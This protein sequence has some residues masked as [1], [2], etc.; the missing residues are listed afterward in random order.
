MTQ[1]RTVEDIKKLGTILGV[2]A[3]PDDE[4]Y[5]MG[6]IMAAAVQ[7][8]QTVACITATR[9]EAGIQD[10]SRW[11]AHKLA[12]I[13]EQELTLCLEIIGDVRHHWLTYKDGHL[14]NVEEQE[15]V[16]AVAELMGQIAP[17][18]ILT[19]GPDGFTGHPDHVTASK[20]AHQ[21]ARLQKPKKPNIFHSVITPQRYEELIGD[22][23]DEHNIFF[24]IEKPPVCLP[25]QCDIL[26]HPPEDI[27]DVKFRALKAQASQTAI[28]IENI[29]ESRYKSGLGE[30]AF[31][32]ADD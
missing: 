17:D 28:M 8:G 5:S 24:N 22:N 32:L 27:L 6:A 2:W 9:G 30:E 29:G 4:S 23:G 1:I 16:T 20:W 26:F 7:N 25:E 12:S 21:A 3:H 19:F 31:V 18:T 15:A 10:E 11:P 14:E 13:R